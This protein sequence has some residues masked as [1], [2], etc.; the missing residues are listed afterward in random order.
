VAHGEHSDPPRSGA[1]RSLSSRVVRA[2]ARSSEHLVVQFFERPDHLFVLLVDVLLGPDLD[3]LVHVDYGHRVG[4]AARFADLLGDGDPPLRVHRRGDVGEPREAEGELLFLS[5][6]GLA[7]RLEVPCPLRF[8]PDLDVGRVLETRDAVQ[9]VRIYKG[10]NPSSYGGRLSSLIDVRMADGMTS[11]FGGTGEIG[12]ISSKLTLQGPMIKEKLSFHLSGRRSYADLLMPYLNPPEY[13]DTRIYFYDTYGKLSA[14]PSPGHTLEL[15]VY[16]GRDVFRNDYAYSCYGNRMASLQ[17][18]FKGRNNLKGGTGITYSDYG[19]QL[20]TFHEN[21]ANSFEWK[22]DIKEFGFRQFFNLTFSSSQSLDFGFQLKHHLFDPCRIRGKGENSLLNDYTLTLGRAYEGSVYAEHAVRLSPGVNITYGIRLTGF[23]DQASLLHKNEAKHLDSDQNKSIRDTKQ[24]R[25]SGGP[26][27]RLKVRWKVTGKWWM[28]L[29]YSRN[30]QFI[31]LAN[32]S[33]AGNPLDVW[34]PSDEKI[35][36]EIS[37]QVVLGISGPL[38]RERLRLSFDAFCKK[39]TRSL[40]FEDHA[41]LMGEENL[42]GHIVQGEGWAGG[43]EFMLAKDAG[44]FNGWIS[45]AF[46]RSFKKFAEI[47]NGESFPSSYDIPHDI[48]VVLN[49]SVSGR[50]NIS[51]AW[52]FTSGKPYT[53]PATAAFINGTTVPLYAS[54]NSSRAPDYHRLDLSMTVR[55]KPGRKFKSEW[56][57]SV[58]NVYNRKNVMSLQFIPEEQNVFDL[59]LNRNYLFPI[60]PSV[61]YRIMF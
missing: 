22:S 35:P 44:R 54:R 34:F 56:I 7:K 3:V 4:D 46:T 19:Y 33:L 57:F 8:R 5:L 9:D 1:R 10:D 45:Y 52:V 26:E 55:N 29:S 20:G 24:H 18:E 32:T 6:I 11:G 16:S 58:Y 21:K 42:A 15:S 39:M 13:K 25:L 27:P 51:A 43:L 30:Q 41:R 38:N 49:Y 2:R 48:A 40:E 37:D 36:P 61:S 23:A 31:H 59:E 17:W 50:V 28:V 47:N 53:A 14:R 12:L 60:M